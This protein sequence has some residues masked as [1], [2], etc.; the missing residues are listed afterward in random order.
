MY[1]CPFVIVSDSDIREVARPAVEEWRRFAVFFRV[2]SVFFTPLP[3][4]MCSRFFANAF[5]G[6]PYRFIRVFSSFC[7]TTRRYRFASS[8]PFHDTFGFLKR[9]H[10]MQIFRKF[11]C[12]V[13]REL[14]KICVY[15]SI[16]TIFCRK[17]R[18]FDNFRHNFFTAETYSKLRT[19]NAQVSTYNYFD[20]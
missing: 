18:K 10:N 1:T 6:S 16:K 19:K 12:T 4:I 2:Q 7:I 3:C 11:S 13:L 14:D 9:L 8:F 5:R 20:K 17:Q 15:G